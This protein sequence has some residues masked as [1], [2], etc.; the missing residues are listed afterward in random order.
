MRRRLMQR[1]LVTGLFWAVVAAVL[2]P[3]SAARAWW[4]DDWSMRKP[5]VVDTGPAGADIAQ[6]VGT[7][8]L[9]VRLHVGNFSFAAANDDGS[10]LR[11]IAGDDETPLA[12]HIERWDPLLG[13]AFV[14]VRVPDVAAGAQTRLWLYYG[15]PQ[16]ASAADS[17]ATFDS[18]TVLAYHFAEPDQPVRDWSAWGNTALT[19]GPVREGALIGSGLRLDGQTRVA[20][21]ASPSLVWN[22]AGEMTWSVW[23]RP[24]L[25]QADAVVFARQDGSGAFTVGIDDGVPFFELAD[26]ATVA[27]AAAGAALQVGAWHHLAVVAGGGRATLL[28]DGAPAAELEAALPPL[29]GTATIGGDAAGARAGFVGE[30]DELRMANI[31]R[32]AGAVAADAVGQG[33]DG[34]RL[35]A[36]GAD[37]QEAGWIGGYTILILGSLT[38]DGWTIIAILLV[39]AVISWVVMADKAIYLRRL[40][41]SN[42]RFLA[43]FRQASEELDELEGLDDPDRAAQ[44]VGALAE[45]DEEVARSSS[46]YRIYRIAVR[47]VDRRARR[48]G[49]AGALSAASLTAIRAALDAGQ[50]REAQK[51]NRMLVVLTIAISGGPFFGL[52]GTVVGV[53]ITF[54]AI[55][56]AGDVNVN[57]IAPGIS[58]A[59][60]TTVVGLGVAIPALFGYNW[61]LTRIRN[62]SATM[63]VFVDE[64]VTRLAEDQGTPDGRGPAA[65]LPAS[66]P[67]E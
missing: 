22:G 59:L 42:S 27:R 55:A 63:S 51:M 30:L 18:H 46:L 26:G 33:A 12:H 17:H 23:V 37:E 39:I 60:M 65:P 66:S 31:A 10:D 53:M 43:S 47:E 21:P 54:A 45:P 25:M 15:N 2:L 32:P 52:L 50:V 14:W 1:F 61:L 34:A 19:A 57:A 38:V 7:V 13:E 62:A 56:A 64:L 16:A 44:P 9:L 20:V 6:P 49:H 29:A 28:V 40:E 3:P 4:N 41:Q 58:A 8:P 24:E 35:L 36:V 11:F 48:R 5:L 67:A